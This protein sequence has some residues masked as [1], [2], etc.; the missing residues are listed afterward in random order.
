MGL[1]KSAI[2][3]RKWRKDFPEKSRRSTQSWDRRNP[4]RAAERARRW[5][6]K[7]HDKVLAQVKKWQAANPEKV[8]ETQRKWREKNPDYS[9]LYSHEWRK[10]HPDHNRDWGRKNPDKM[11]V[12]NSKRRTAVSGNGGS[13]TAAEW[14]ALCR[15]CKHRCL[16]CGKRRKLTA[17]HVVPVSKGGD[18]SISNIQPLC[19]PCN[20]RKGTKATD[21]RKTN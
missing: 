21:Y 10:S 8:K 4:G 3:N 7:N 14:N 13:F 16:C 17:D 6:K 1:S 12:K 11:R 9:K 19:K 18:S 5:R 2:R 20:S 15:Q